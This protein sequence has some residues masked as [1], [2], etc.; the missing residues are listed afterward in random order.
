MGLVATSS[1]AFAFSPADDTVWL[2]SP[3]FLERERNPDPDLLDCYTHADPWR[4]YRWRVGGT[5]DDLELVATGLPSTIP[6]LPNSIAVSPDGLIA[7]S[8]GSSSYTTS[9]EILATR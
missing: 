6:V 7:W 2:A 3:C 1:L 9:A 4:L 5:P 8:I